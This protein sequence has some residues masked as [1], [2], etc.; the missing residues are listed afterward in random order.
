MTASLTSTFPGY[1][2]HIGR[3]RYTRT[4]THTPGPSISGGGSVQHFAD[5]TMFMAMASILATYDILP[6]LDADGKLVLPK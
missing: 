3:T 1:S 6:E 4:P 2:M 5:L